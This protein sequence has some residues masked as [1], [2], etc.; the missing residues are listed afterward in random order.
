[1]VVILKIRKRKAVVLAM[2]KAKN[3]ASWFIAPFLKRFHELKAKNDRI[4]AILR[5]MP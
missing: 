4:A 3:S 2:I 5:R 1:M